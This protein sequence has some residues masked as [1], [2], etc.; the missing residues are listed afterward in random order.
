MTPPK[1][2]N[3]RKKG[4]GSVF[5]NA[6]RDRW[7]GTISKTENGKR[8]RRSVTGATQAEVED[9]LDALMAEFTAHTIYLPKNLGEKAA[10]KAAKRKETLSDVVRPAV[11]EYVDE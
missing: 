1:G 5:Y 6:T 4:Q 2:P 10:A 3:Q 7:E 9:K 8:R 11:E